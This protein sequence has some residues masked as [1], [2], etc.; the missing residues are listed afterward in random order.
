VGGS[1][2]EIEPRRG[3]RIFVSSFAPTG[4]DRLEFPTHGSRRGLRLLRPSGAHGPAENRRMFMPDRRSLR[5]LTNERRH[6]AGIKF[7][8]P[9]AGA[10][11]SLAN[12]LPIW[13]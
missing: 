1:Q 3:E 13:L 11:I 5:A 4:L 6:F 2:K 7:R 12:Q 8:R 10:D 9:L